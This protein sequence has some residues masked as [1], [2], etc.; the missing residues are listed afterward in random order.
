MNTD[1]DRS[2]PPLRWMVFEAGAL[3]LRTAPFERTYLDPEEQIE[4]QESLT[5]HW[6]LL[7]ILPF[8]RPTY[9]REGKNKTTRWSVASNCFLRHFSQS[10]TIRPH[11]GASRKIHP[12]QRI[13]SSLVLSGNSE[14]TPKARPLKSEGPAFWRNLHEDVGGRRRDWLEHD[15]YEYTWDIVNRFVS[16]G[17][18]E[19]STVLEG[20]RQFIT[21]SKFPGFYKKFGLLT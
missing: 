8:N 19:N 16:E 17:N 9:T 21:S 1:L 3:G 20:L 18:Q 6:W 4:V 2:R 7:E 13:H 11:L 12:G 5:R 15:L 14:Y 10:K